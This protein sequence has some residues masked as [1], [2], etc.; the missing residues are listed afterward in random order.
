L[1]TPMTIRSGLSRLVPMVKTR[2]FSKGVSDFCSPVFTST[3]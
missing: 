1:F 2:V 3:P